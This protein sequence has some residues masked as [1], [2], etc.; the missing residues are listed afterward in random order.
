M[1]LKKT[2]AE[3]DDT[4]IE[5][6]RILQE[7]ARITMRDLS[8]RIALSPPSTAERVRRLEEGGFIRGYRAQLDP[9]IL[10]YTTHAYILIGKISPD[11]VRQF[12]QDVQDIP[13]IV[14]VEKLFTGGYHAIL[15]IYCQS[16]S[17]LDKVQYRLLELGYGE[18]T[19]MLCSP[20]KEKQSGLPLDT[21][22][23]R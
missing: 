12:Y 8:Q 5:I 11:K 19:T 7:E 3:L 9:S 4:D 15:N 14:S 23:D 1:P 6:L 2:V 16:P 21:M 18:Q 13:E 17:H 10:G 22:E 20:Q